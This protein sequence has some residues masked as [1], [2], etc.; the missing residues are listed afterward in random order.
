MDPNGS[1][2]IRRA[3]GKLSAEPITVYQ[4]IGIGLP[5]QSGWMHDDDLPKNVTAGK[6]K[7]AFKEQYPNYGKTIYPVGSKTTQSV[8]KHDPNNSKLRERSI[9]ISR[10]L[11]MPPD[12]NATAVLAEEAQGS[13]PKKKNGGSPNKTGR[14]KVKDETWRDNG[15]RHSE[16][17]E[18]DSD[19]VGNDD[20]EGG[21]LKRRK[22]KRKAAAAPT[23]PANGGN[24]SGNEDGENGDGQPKQ[25]KTRTQIKLVSARGEGDQ[26]HGQDMAAV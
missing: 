12:K 9:E 18:P 19:Q 7:E 16:D 3:R 24:A 5:N 6:V 11:P 13:E 10:A 8:W 22:R 23:T 17:S 20:P 25:K 15:D 26:R 1:C 21:P 2:R 14:K 4:G